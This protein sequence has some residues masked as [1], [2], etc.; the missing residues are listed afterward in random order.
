MARVHK[1][2]A[3]FGKTWRG[4]SA[5]FVGEADSERFAEFNPP[6]PRRRPPN[7][8]MARSD[9][10][11]DPSH[12]QRASRTRL[13]SHTRLALRGLLLAVLCTPL[14]A[15]GSIS[16]WG[17]DVAGQVSEAPTGTG[18]TQVAARAY[19][20]LALRAD[21]S[22][23]A[24]GNSGW[25]PSDVVDQAP[26]GTGFTKISAGE[27]HALALR[28]DG[29][30]FGWGVDSFAQVSGVPGGTGFT[31]IEAGDE[32]SFA[33]AADGSIVDWGSAFS[34][35]RSGVPTGPGYV[36]LSVSYFFGVALHSDGSIVVWGQNFG[37]QITDAPTGNDFLQAEAGN[38]SLLAL[39]NDGTLVTWGYELHDILAN[40]PT[41]NN[42]VQVSIGYHIT[43]STNYALRTDGSI[44]AWGLFNSGQVSGVPQ[45]TGFSRVEGGGY[46]ALALHPEASGNAFCFGDGSGATCP[47]NATGGSGQG[48]ANSSGTD[49]A[50]LQAAGYASLTADSFQFTVHGLPNN[51][52]GMLLRS[53]TAL[54]GGSGSP[55]G[56][57]LFC[58]SGL[59]ARSQV[60]LSLGGST[61]FTHFQG[62]PFGWSSYGLNTTTNYQ[63]WYRDQSNLCS[64]DGF[65][66][67]NAWTVT[68]LP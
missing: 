32:A 42:F 34:A 10:C 20:S 27:E 49:G 14:S 18:F 57:G 7:I 17:Y 47:C 45:G 58:S 61:T 64:G 36:A 51:K 15:Q 21:G 41:E 54:A 4:R 62:L 59:V 22:I 28:E 37:G 19:Y 23:L 55:L 48:C 52:P 44:F 5:D 30:I 67:S 60:Q 6:G 2:R 53:N 40:T 25:N 12:T 13:A 50:T 39:R 35:L 8:P 31:Q 9:F 43:G 24:W 26:T 65:N 16:A 46:H 11:A 56:D 66:F 38:H 1:S 68:W 3:F 63:C 29:S 33:I